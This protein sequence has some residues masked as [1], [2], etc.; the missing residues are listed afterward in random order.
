MANVIDANTRLNAGAYVSFTSR[1]RNSKVFFYGN[2][3]KITFGTY[4]KTLTPLSETDSFLTITKAFEY[5][6]DL[7]SYKVYSS[8]D[9]WWKILEFN[10]MME[11]FD[12]KAGVNIRLPANFV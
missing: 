3:R 6:P 12:F 1:Y 9:Y 5:R 8:P 10:N 11:I 7:V 2:E 4:K